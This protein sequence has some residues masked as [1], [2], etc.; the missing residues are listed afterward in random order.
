[1]K[2]EGQKNFKVRKF[3]NSLFSDTKK[4]EK[5][6]MKKLFEKVDVD[7]TATV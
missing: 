7:F 6:A 4:W 1:M 2:T 5:T 3:E